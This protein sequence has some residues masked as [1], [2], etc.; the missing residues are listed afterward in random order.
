MRRAGLSRRE[1]KAVLGIGN[2]TLGQALKDEPPPAWTRRPNAK[3][4]TRADARE[5]RA[6]GPSLKE[7]V[8][9]L[10][11]SKSS[12]SLWVRDPELPPLSDEECRRRKAEA[13]QRYWARERPLRD[14]RRQAVRGAAADEV[15]KL[16]DR[17]IVI[18][19]AI[20]YWCEGAK[21]KPYRRAE[22]VTFINSDPRL[23]RFFLRFLE[24]AG[25]AREQ[26][27]SASISTNSRMWGQ[28]SN[29]GSA[30]PERERPSS[31]GRR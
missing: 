8:A 2:S 15:G 23:I 14:A 13:S 9:K 31:A 18:A 27:P 22:R 29:S 21:N 3:D 7:I 19:G 25:V 12:V 4:D 17:E 10:G 26:L 5:L 11:V 16:S 30:S 28:R 24:V 1:I 6:Q 20:A